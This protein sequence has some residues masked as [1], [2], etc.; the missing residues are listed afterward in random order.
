[1]ARHADRV[2]SAVN[3]PNAHAEHVLSWRRCV[4]VHGLAPEAR[5]ERAQL[6]ARELDAAREATADL[7]TAAAQHLDRL[8]RVFV[9]TGCC[10]ALTDAR[11]VV[12][13][14][15]SADGD[16]RDF[17]EVGLCE[18]ADWGEAAMGTNGI[19]TALAEERA[20]VIHRDKHFLP[21][22]T[23][24]S[25][26]TTPIRDAH[27][28]IAGSLDISSCRYDATEP[29][30]GVFLLAAQEAA[31]QIESDMF[32]AAF[33]GARLVLAPGRGGPQGLLAL[34]ADDLVI[35]ANHAARRALGIDDAALASPR[36]VE[37]LMGEAH[38]APAP[39][40]EAAER[41]TLRLA[42]AQSGGNVSAAATR[43]GVSRATLHR[44]LKRLDLR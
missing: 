10:V 12:L 28:R 14:R 33:P 40:F 43:L 18:G 6:G 7:V 21:A 37:E 34:D 44:K 39:G 16:A 2:W 9:R 17:R 24:L 36:T 42:L 19:G 30:L 4:R 38:G 20:V 29:M 15:R 25:C 23:R 31:A 27:A 3:Q 41:R 35:G 5:G 1:M 8:S 26:A 11:G 22:N 32:R 13:E